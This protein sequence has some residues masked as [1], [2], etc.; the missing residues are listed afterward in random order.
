MDLAP[1]AP[2][3]AAVLAGVPFPFA[4]DLDPGAVD[5][6]VQRAV[7]TAI[8]DVH[9]QGLLAP[10]QRAEVGHIPVQA[11]QT[12]QALD[13]P[14]R[15][16]QRHAEQHL[17]RQT[18]LDGGV[19]VVGLPPT[20]AGRRCLPSH[21]RI[22]PDRQRATALQRFVIGGP[23]PGLVGGGRWSA[24]AAQLPCWIHKMNPSRDLCNRAST[25]HCAGH[26]DIVW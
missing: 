22:E 20:L 19:A 5:Q 6:Q 9:L 14:C 21:R 23:V 7:R 11:D 25:M 12:Q 8:G 17:H 26:V 10:R 4:L 16:P 18:G 1:D 2:L 15:L 13:Q 3:G 24:H